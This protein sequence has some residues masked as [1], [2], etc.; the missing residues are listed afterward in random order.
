MRS[1]TAVLSALA[2][3]ALLA[4]GC[5][6]PETAQC[7]G[8]RVADFGFQGTLVPVADPAYDRIRA[9]DP[10]SYLP[11]CTPDPS[12]TSAPIQYE[13][14]L[15]GFDARLAADPETDGAA[16]CRPN[17]SV[18]SGTR[19]GASYAV[20]ATADSGF[21]CSSA[22]GVSLHV[23]VKGAVAVD[24]VGAPTAFDGILVEALAEEGGTCDACLPTIPTS[25]PAARGCAARYALTGTPY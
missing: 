13:Q 11:D 18:L 3:S 1:S 17:G 7:P 4:A 24:G 22:C 16:L 20:E 2:A 12:D 10:V 9:L 8:A 6:A 15:P 25:S 19:S 23:Y 14:A 5:T 21:V